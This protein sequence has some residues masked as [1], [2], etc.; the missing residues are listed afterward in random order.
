MYYP[1]RE[2]VVIELEL[3][4]VKLGFCTLCNERVYKE[5]AYVKASEGYCHRRCVLKEEASELKA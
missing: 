3:S 1:A 4:S 5:E 2:G